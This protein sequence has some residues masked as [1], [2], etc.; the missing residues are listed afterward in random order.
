MIP[1]PDHRR[2]PH[3]LPQRQTVSPVTH[4]IPEPRFSCGRPTMPPFVTPW[5]PHVLP[6]VSP[7]WTAGRPPHLCP[8]PVQ[9]PITH[10][11]HPRGH[12][13]PPYLGPTATPTV[14]SCKGISRP[15][16]TSARVPFPRAPPG[17]T[18]NGSTRRPPMR[19]ARST[20]APSLHPQRHVPVAGF[21]HPPLS[22][23]GVIRRPCIVSPNFILTR[24]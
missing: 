21:R 17:T 22:A 18:A 2:C 24:W 10:D 7:P 13:H 16:P 4:P 23:G 1:H 3:R 15:I 9:G 5:T 12:V 11:G 19:A 14:P 6:P 8:T 20:V